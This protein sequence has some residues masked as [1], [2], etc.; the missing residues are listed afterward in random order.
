MIPSG[1]RISVCTERKDMRRSFDA[2]TLAVVNGSR[3]IPKAVLCSSSQASE[4]TALNSSVPRLR[5]RL[6][7]RPYLRTEC[8]FDS[9][10]GERAE[11]N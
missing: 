9:P 6:V 11:S 10:R 1:V 2:L 4:S 5:S 7:G 3:A 8:R